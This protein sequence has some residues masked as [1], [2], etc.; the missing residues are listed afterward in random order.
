MIRFESGFSKSIEG[1]LSKIMIDQQGG[2]FIPET[3]KAIGSSDFRTNI[4]KISKSNIDAVFLDMLDFDIVK[5]LNDSEKLGFAK[6]IIGYTTL[7]DVLKK[8]IDKSG[9]EGAI[10]LDWE[11]PSEEFSAKFFEKY[12]EYPR[13]GANK[14]Y[15]SVY[16]LAEAIANSND[17][18]EVPA[19]IKKHSFKTVNGEFL[20]GENNAVTDTPVKVFEV[21]SGKLVEIKSYI[22]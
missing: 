16:M 3:Y 12:G 9:L 2:S 10:M 15:D 19:Y 8:D 22:K 20:F 17:R 21:S 5:Y 4:L 11:I 14:S 13:R 6:P 7:R 1:T 18:S